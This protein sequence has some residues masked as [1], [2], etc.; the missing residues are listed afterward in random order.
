MVFGKA[1]SICLRQRFQNSAVVSLERSGWGALT[2]RRV[3]SMRPSTPGY[4]DSVCVNDG[5][6]YH[7]APEE[8]RLLREENIHMQTA[9]EPL[10]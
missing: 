8:T 4:I 5:K 7:R 3:D 6:Q 2:H 10:S 1:G 9:I